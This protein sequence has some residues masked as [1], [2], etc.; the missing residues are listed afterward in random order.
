MSHRQ[1]RKMKAELE[2]IK[3]V[4]PPKE[5]SPGRVRAEVQADKVRRPYTG[6]LC[7]QVNESHK[8]GGV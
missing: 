7:G 5:P 6:V 3:K 4:R 1:W 2:E 8:A